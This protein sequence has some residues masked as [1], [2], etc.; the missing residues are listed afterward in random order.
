M[1]QEMRLEREAEPQPRRGGL[2]I[3]CW[4]SSILANGSSHVHWLDNFYV[5]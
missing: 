1:V 3:H 4:V 5:S 2:E